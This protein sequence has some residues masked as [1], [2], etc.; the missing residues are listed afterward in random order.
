M[1][2]ATLPGAD[3]TW[4]RFSILGWE[5]LGFSGFEGVR[6]LEFRAPVCRPPWP[7]TVVLLQEQQGDE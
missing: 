3:G 7:I 1:S 4:F 2:T 5:C 6:V